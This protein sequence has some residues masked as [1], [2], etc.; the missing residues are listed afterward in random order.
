MSILKKPLVVANWKL[1][2]TKSDM[3]KFFND[4]L[5]NI[6]NNNIDIAI[7]PVNTILDAASVK[8]QNSEVFL[9]AQNVF[10]TQGA[11][12]GECSVAHLLEIGVKYCIIGHS[13]RRQI[14]FEKD[15]DVNKKALA[16]LQ[17]NIIPI[18]CIGENKEQRDLGLVKK[19]ITQQLE[20]ALKGIENFTKPF[21]IAYEPIWAIGT[22]ITPSEAEI[23][24][25]MSIIRLILE[26]IF[27]INKAKETILLY[28]GSVNEKNID[29]LAK[30]CSIDGVLVGG[31]SLQA[32]SFLTIVKAISNLKG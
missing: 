29:N 16:C 5:P 7:A 24:D 18:I 30:K 4:F 8:L 14:F 15:E 27:D 10:Y 22:G 9:C 17:N 13:E 32:S 12:T 31:A 3:N 25:A 20:N 28:G 1:N 26:E 6:N 11:Y 19:I 21:I 2:H 23:N